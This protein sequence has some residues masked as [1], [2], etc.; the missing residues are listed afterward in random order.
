MEYHLESIEHVLEGPG[1]SIQ[2]I[3]Q[4]TLRG[5]VLIN[6][7]EDEARWMI[8]NLMDLRTKWDREDARNERQQQD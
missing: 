8:A 6:I 2:V 7:P 1:R 4:D 3:A 5:R